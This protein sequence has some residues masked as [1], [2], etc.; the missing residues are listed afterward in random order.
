[1]GIQDW[2]GPL[3]VFRDHSDNEW[4]SPCLGNCIRAKWVITSG[5]KIAILAARLLVCL[6]PR[7]ALRGGLALF[8]VHA[9][10]RFDYA[11]NLGNRIDKALIIGIVLVLTTAKCVDFFPRLVKPHVLARTIVIRALA[12]ASS[13]LRLLLFTRHRSRPRRVPG[14]CAS[15]DMSRANLDCRTCSH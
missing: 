6:T 12:R 7:T 8:R 14:N 15:R 5:E 13:G 11:E 3:R 1:L 4:I 9:A 10:E 2:V